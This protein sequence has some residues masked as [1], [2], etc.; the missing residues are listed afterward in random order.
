MDA[1]LSM[2]AARIK[3]VSTVVGVASW[4]GYDYSREGENHPCPRCESVSSSRK[5]LR[6]FGEHRW[7][8]FHCDDGGDEIDWL[9]GKLGVSKGL[10]I[11]TLAA[12]LGISGEIGDVVE[13][14]KH[15]LFKDR[16]RSLASESVGDVEAREVLKQF[17]ASRFGKRIDPKWAAAWIAALRMA[18]SSGETVRARAVG[19]AKSMAKYCDDQPPVIERSIRHLRNEH[20]AAKYA[21]ALSADRGAYRRLAL[22]RRWLTDDAA[23]FLIGAAIDPGD[24]LSGRIVFPVRDAS[25]RTVGFT[26]RIVDPTISRHPGAKYLNSAEESG[27][28]K[29]R[30]L[31]GFDL[32]LPSMI[33]RG[34]AVIV[35]GPADVIACHRDDVTEAVAPC[36]SAMTACHAEMLSIV[37]SRVVLIGDGDAAGR[38]A[39]RRWAAIARGARLDVVTVLMPKDGD[40]DEYLEA[41]GSGALRSIVARA[42]EVDPLA[43]VSR[44]LSSR[45]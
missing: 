4:F 25:S 19:A 23:P 28:S 3:E 38:E 16:V 30:E 10:A 37:C 21:A 40:P 2:V 36:G 9:A 18:R 29:G 22:L 45:A 41:K 24:F 14:I 5:T 26:G 27:F 33:A 6:V 15:R 13:L 31:F 12:R 34:R 17:R 44:D 43:R 32:A 39:M 20:T 42:V 8:C 11:R 1:P 7:H 35:E